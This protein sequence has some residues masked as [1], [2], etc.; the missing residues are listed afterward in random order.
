MIKKLASK[1]MKT[2][3]TVDSLSATPLFAYLSLKIDFKTAKG[4]K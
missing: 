3:L 1:L 2:V 4:A